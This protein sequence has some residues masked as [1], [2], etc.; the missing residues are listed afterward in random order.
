[1]HP[2]CKY[3]LAIL[4][5]NESKKDAFEKSM[6]LFINIRKYLILKKNI[7]NSFEKNDIFHLYD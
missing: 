4:P 2:L 7:Y 5:I 6:I 3:K 1:M